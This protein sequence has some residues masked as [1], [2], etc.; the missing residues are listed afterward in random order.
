MPGVIWVIMILAVVGM[1]VLLYALLNVAHTSDERA[2]Y[3]EEY[4]LDFDEEDDF[5]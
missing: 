2:G 5:L 1:L 4:G 3:M